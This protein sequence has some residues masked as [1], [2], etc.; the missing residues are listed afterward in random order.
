ME[1]EDDWWDDEESVITTTPADSGDSTS[2]DTT[3]D[4]A[5]DIYVHT[6]DQPEEC[7]PQFSGPG[8]GMDTADSSASSGVEITLLM[9]TREPSGGSGNAT[10]GSSRSGGT[11]QTDSTAGSGLGTVWRLPARVDA[12]PGPSPLPQQAASPRA[13]GGPGGAVGK[14]VGPVAASSPRARAGAGAGAWGSG[15]GAASGPG[16]PRA[17]GAAAQAAAAPAAAGTPRAKAVAAA[18][19]AAAAAPS[20]RAGARPA[21]GPP[22]AG[23]GAGAGASAAAQAAGHVLAPLGKPST[24]G[25]PAAKAS[26]EA[27]TSGRHSPLVAL[28]PSGRGDAGLPRT[29][30]H[31]G[32]V[33]AGA[34]ERRQPEPPMKPRQPGRAGAPANGRALRPLGGPQAGAG[35]R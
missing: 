23:A 12:G 32:M 10:A 2:A 27:A 8:M 13:K 30:S 1:Y 25:G 26:L 31:A 33:A 24:P 29:G 22:G 18:A 5:P 7:P 16:T 34:E 35:P 4:R 15:A 9:M 28:T 19:A 3:A 14:G 6:Y 20:P 11:L 21:K 17:P